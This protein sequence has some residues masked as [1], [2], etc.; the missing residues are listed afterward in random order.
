[1]VQRRSCCLELPALSLSPS[2]W[3]HFLCFFHLSLNPE[4]SFSGLLGWTKDLHSALQ[5]SPRLSL[6]VWC[7]LGTQHHGLRSYLVLS[8]PSKLLLLHYTAWILEDS[9]NP[10]CNN[11][12]CFYWCYSRTLTNSI[13]SAKNRQATLEFTYVRSLL[14]AFLSPL[15]RTFIAPPNHLLSFTTPAQLL[16]SFPAAVLLRS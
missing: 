8:L 13:A 11:M 6:P 5:E 7:C 10:L 9:F 1:M 2:W 14:P 12:Y 4:A 16:A 3:L 15:S